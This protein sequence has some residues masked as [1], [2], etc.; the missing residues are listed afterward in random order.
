MGHIGLSVPC[1]KGSP[2]KP[3]LPKH[4]KWTT[5]TLNKVTHP[6]GEARSMTP[7][8]LV[9]GLLLVTSV[10]EKDVVAGAVPLGK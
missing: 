8:C 5:A 10:T 2:D 7:Y 9:R 4:N 6:W 1:P 3:S